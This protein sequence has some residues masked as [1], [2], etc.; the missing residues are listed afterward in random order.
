MA[1][2]QFIRHLEYYGFPDQNRYS[3]DINTVDLSDIIEKNKEQDKEIAD[4]EGEKA[5]KKDLVELSGTVDTLITTQSEINQEFVTILSGVTSDIETL[6]EIDNEF[7]SQLSALTNATNDI[8]EDVNELSGKVISFSSETLNSLNEKLDKDI[9]EE[10]FAE[11]EDTYTKEEVDNLISGGVSGYATVEWVEEQGYINQNF[12]DNRYA[13]K[14]T[15][16]ALSDR[17]NE[18]VTKLGTD[19]Y[20]LSGDYTTFKTT[21]S[22]RM[23]TLETNF[24]TLDGK[25][26]REINQI[27]ATVET[28][29]NRIEANEDAIEDLTEDVNRKA[30]KSDLD[31]LSGTV[32]TISTKVDDKVGKT[33]FNTYKESINNRFNR[34]DENKADKSDLVPITNSAATLDSKIEQE[35]QDRINGDNALQTEIDEVNTEI[36]NL[37]EKDVTHTTKITELEIDLTQE[38]EDRIQGDKNLIGT[39]S[40]T[41]NDDTIW[42]A[43]RFAQNQKAQAISAANE[44]TNQEITRVEGNLE[45]EHNWAEQNFSSCVTSS[46]VATALSE[47]EEEVESEITTA[48]TAEKQRAEGVEGNLLTRILALVEDV[49]EDDTKISNLAT[50]VKCIT[51]WEG[52]DPAQYDDSGNG[53]LDVLHREF[54]EYVEKDGIIESIEDLI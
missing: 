45:R 11:K 10:T 53:I 31:N 15:V 43:K 54:H 9:A 24:T 2:K 48:V 1:K 26:N 44:Y 17:L 51:A 27:S 33:E 35:I 29:S 16:E 7:G 32:Y 25:V 41:L 39:T 22:A 42:G 40:D 8:I 46:Y 3:S 47:L 50:K 23:G 20:S 38:V 37:K 18:S 13:K 28:F 12:A 5:D 19:I 49:Q 4:L 36:I 6:K 14:E 30:N 21:T 34:F 52:D